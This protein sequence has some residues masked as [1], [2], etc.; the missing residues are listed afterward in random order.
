MT[1][2]LADIT[3][4]S[5]SF[6]AALYPREKL[7]PSQWAEKHRRL[8]DDESSEPGP[9]TFDRTPYWRAVCDAILENVE[10][11]V[12]LKGAQVGWSEICRNV[13][14]YWID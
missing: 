11:V 12:C 1:P 10:E 9:Y 2:G 5:T 6:W 3:I 8:G 7:G 4:T 13:L 14:G